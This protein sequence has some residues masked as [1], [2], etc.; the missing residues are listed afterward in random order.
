[1]TTLDLWD[2]FHQ[3]L[4]SFILRR[5]SDPADAEDVL[6]E[7]FLRLH[8]HLGALRQED[9]LAPWVYQVCRNAIVDYYRRRRPAGALSEDLPGETPVPPGEDQARQAAVL[10]DGMLD[11]LPE[12]YRQALVYTE[13]EG[14]TQV[15]LAEFLGLGLSAAKSRVQRARAMLRQA[16]LACC[17][18]EFDRRGGVIDYAPRCSCCRSPA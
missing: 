12:K 3:E 11:G 7:V 16:L 14:H 4:L 18:F 2:D 8:T 13:I 6:Q 5:V 10:L 1:M 15:E 17:H 9:R